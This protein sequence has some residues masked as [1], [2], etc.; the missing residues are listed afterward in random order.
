MD[1]GQLQRKNQV[2]SFENNQ[3]AAAG[4]GAMTLLSILDALAAPCLSRVV[5]HK[6]IAPKSRPFARSSPLASPPISDSQFS[7]PNFPDSRTLIPPHQSPITPSRHFFPT[8]PTSPASIHQSINP[9]I[10]QPSPPRRRPRSAFISPPQLPILHF[11][12]PILNPPPRLSSLRPLRFLR[13]NLSSRIAKA[14]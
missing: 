5:N 12:F 8:R 14:T 2:R 7:I 9:P 10:Q 1:N 6:P 3:P 4:N 13:L 11:Q